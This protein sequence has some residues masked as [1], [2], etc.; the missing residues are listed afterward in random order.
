MSLSSFRAY[1]IRGTYP[2]DINE[3]LAYK[4]GRAFVERFNLN[5]V[6]VGRDL[7]GSGLGLFEALAHGITDQGCDVWDIGVTTTPNVSFYLS[8][9][10]AD[11]GISISGSHN[12]G[13]DNAFKLVRYPIFQVSDEDGLFDIRDAV[14]RDEFGQA[15]GG[16]KII[17]KNDAISIYQDHLRKFIKDIKGLKV[18]VDYGNGVGSITADKIFKE[19]DIEY[20]PL[21]AEP[22]MSFPNHEANPHDVANFKDL[23]DKIKE[24]GADIGIFFD[25]DA[26][27]SQFVDENGEIV[28]PDIATSLLAEDAL[29]R[30]PG[31]KVYYDLRF[32]RA[33]KERIEGLDG[34]PVMM[35]VGNPF[36]K[37]RLIEEGGAIAA[38]FSGHMMFPEN[39]GLDD[40]MFA[41]IEIL[42][43]LSKSDQKFSELLGPCM[44][45]AA[46]PELNYTV[47]NA[48]ETLREVADAFKDGKSTEL[49]G[50]Y[51]EYEDWWFNLRK[52]NT[53]PKV[54]LRVEAESQELME[55]KRDQII[56]IINTLK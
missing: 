26:D 31:E 21:Y 40:G 8:Q 36:Y 38:E 28:F 42:S 32:S 55:E 18:V 14:A 48:D 22:D 12:P 7:R 39:F 9:N 52:S 1:D 47:Q 15:P 51:I 5:S 44:K 30:H 11:A 43:V 49:D 2:A 35:R 27:R 3:D 25:G 34:K 20:I 17:V 37:R 29:K 13:Q 46:T 54:R 50:V 10:K 16:G 53:E 45:Y 4:V 33:V 23:Q 24:T 19:M 56:D 6:V 41:G